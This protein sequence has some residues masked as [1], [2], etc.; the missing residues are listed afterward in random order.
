MIQLV[1]GSIQRCLALSPTVHMMN[2]VAMVPVTITPMFD[3][4]RSLMHIMEAR[5]PELHETC[6]IT[7]ADT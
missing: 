3:G 5:D 6:R 2:E 1:W 7:I 4:K